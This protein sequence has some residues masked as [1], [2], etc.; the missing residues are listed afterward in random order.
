MKEENQEK[1]KNRIF[2][3]HIIRLIKIFGV[4][5]ERCRL[6]D[7]N[8]QKVILTICGLARLMIDSFIL[9]KVIKN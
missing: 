4:P 6:K 2:V 5:R 1:A 7:N 3:E 8:Y 9:V